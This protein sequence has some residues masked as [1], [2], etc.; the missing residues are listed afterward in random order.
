MTSWA[1]GLCLYSLHLVVEEVV[2][3]TG[4]LLHV[5]K[6]DSESLSQKKGR[7]EDGQKEK[8]EE[9]RRKERKKERKKERVLTLTF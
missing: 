6:L 7:K 4:I 1:E 5:I 9:R 2:V 3:E 8:K